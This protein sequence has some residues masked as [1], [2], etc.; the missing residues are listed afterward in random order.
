MSAGPGL[1]VVISWMTWCLSGFFTKKL[2][3]FSLQL[4]QSVRGYVNTVYVHIIGSC[5]SLLP[6]VGAFPLSSRLSAVRKSFPRGWL[7]GFS[8]LLDQCPLLCTVGPC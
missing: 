7:F 4:I 6:V 2:L 8:G 1:V 5:L 3:F